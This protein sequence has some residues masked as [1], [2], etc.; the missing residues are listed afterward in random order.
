MFDVRRLGAALSELTECEASIIV[1]RVSSNPPKRRPA[2]SLAFELGSAEMICA[3][4]L[5]PELAVTALGRMLRRPIALSSHGALDDS[6]LGALNALVLELA[7]RSGAQAA[8][9]VHDP[10]DALLRADDVYVEAT[11]LL[12]GTAY[13]VLAALRLPELPH[14]APIALPAL[15]ELPIAVSVVVGWSLAERAL[16]ADFVPGNAWF[17]G[18][19][20]WLDAQLTGAVALAAPGQESGIAGTLSRDGK[21]MLRGGSIPLLPDAGELMSD[22]AK[23]EATLTDA[24]LESPVVVRVEVGAVTLTAREWAELGPGD[25]IETGRRIAEPVVLRVAGREVARG[26]LV[27]LEGELGVRIREVIRS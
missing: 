25:I 18:A 4:S 27:N 5:E 2:T 11:V 14:D 15:G 13:Q 24:V 12:D 8:L 19:G 3:L 7:R 23:P 20:L 17:P 9:H 10:G 26:E 1:R 16:L 6:L 22:P 21:I